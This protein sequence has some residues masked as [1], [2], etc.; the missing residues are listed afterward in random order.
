MAKGTDAMRTP[1]ADD[2]EGLRHFLGVG[3]VVESDVD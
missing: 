3:A 2:L 1:K